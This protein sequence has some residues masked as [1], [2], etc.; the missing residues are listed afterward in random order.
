MSKT[1]FTLK[2]RT[3]WQFSLEDDPKKVYTLPAL[4]GL[5]YEEAD[6]MKKIGSM[7]KIAEQGPLI[8]AFILTYAPELEEMGLGDMEYYEIFNAYGLS[9]GK[10]KL[11]ESEASRNS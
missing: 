4:S 2:R 1:T 7:D 9:E 5:S 10:N 6:R 8:K 3:D 11:G